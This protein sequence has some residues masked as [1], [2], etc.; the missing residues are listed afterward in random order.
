MGQPLYTFLLGSHIFM[1]TALGSCVKRPSSVVCMRGCVQNG[2][3]LFLDNLPTTIICTMQNSFL[4][5]LYCRDLHI[6]QEKKQGA[7]AR[8]Y[9]Y[10]YIYQV[11]TSE[12][13][14]AEIFGHNNP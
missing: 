6:S 7:I 5:S 9:I 2:F 3:I 13:V 14:I 12:S 4:L 10:V 8:P 1:V 11:R